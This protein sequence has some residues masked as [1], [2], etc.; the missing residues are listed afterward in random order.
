VKLAEP[1]LFPGIAAD[2]SY[3][4]REWL[5]RITLYKN[6]DPLTLVI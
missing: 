5:M 4:G 3:L 6:I 2:F 1:P